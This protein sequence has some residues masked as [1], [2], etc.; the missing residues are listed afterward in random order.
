MTIDL[1]SYSTTTQMNAA[2]AA[3]LGPYVLTTTLGT[4][5]TAA[6]MNTQISLSLIPY[7]PYVP[8]TA[9][10]NTLAAYTDTTN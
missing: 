10:P 1:T 9:L 7:V 2:I 4:Y 5:S 8:N 3:A 6:Q